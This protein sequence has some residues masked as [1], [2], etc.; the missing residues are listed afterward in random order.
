[1]IEPIV[2]NHYTRAIRNNTNTSSLGVIENT[3]LNTGEEG[4]NIYSY[5]DAIISHGYNLS[6][7]DGSGFLIAAGDQINTDPTLGPLQNNG[8]LTETY[9]LLRGSP[10]INAGD[11]VILFNPNEF[12]QRGPGFPRVVGGRIDIGAVEM[13]VGRRPHRRLASQYQLPISSSDLLSSTDG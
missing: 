2:I 5:R 9:A 12:D 8:G 4:S 11:P 7:D 1:M 6:S 3:I 10:A 13:K